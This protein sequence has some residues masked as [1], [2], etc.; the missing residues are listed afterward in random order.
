M[1]TG[2]F[3]YIVHHKVPDH[4]ERGWRWIAH[5]GEYSCLMWWCCGECRD[6]EVP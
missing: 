4:M 1:K 2:V 5:L 6:E 3:R